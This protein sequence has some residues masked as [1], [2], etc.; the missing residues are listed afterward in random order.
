MTTQNLSQRKNKTTHRE[1]RS[2]ITNHR[3]ITTNTRSMTT[4]IRSMITN[5]ALFSLSNED[6]D[7]LSRDKLFNSHCQ[8]NN[9][10]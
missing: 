2:I 4:N 3:S 7:W 10:I 6:K 5:H 1:P 9:I 8:F